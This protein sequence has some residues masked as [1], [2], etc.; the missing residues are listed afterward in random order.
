M[1]IPLPHWVQRL[2]DRRKRF[3]THARRY[4]R[5][6]AASLL[7][8]R[9][10]SAPLVR[11]L[12]G[13]HLLEVFTARASEL[14][15]PR[16]IPS[17]YQIRIATRDDETALGD[18]FGDLDRVH[19]RRQRGDVCLIACCRE[20][21]CAAVWF[22][23]GP[24][25]YVDDWDDLQCR[26]EL[27]AGAV[28]SYDGKGTKLGAWGSLMAKLPE[29]LREWGVDRVFTAIDYHN[30]QSLSGHQSLGYRRLGMVRRVALPGI[31]RTACK[32][33]DDSWTHLPADWDR[34][35]L[36]A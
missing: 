9:L 18:Y 17:N 31:S 26:F 25:S 35:Q 23:P 7:L 24:A 34:L 36:N 22:V 4:G 6:R 27:P 29:Q 32:S 2:Q 1:R 30:G 8:H 15:V 12:F 20:E 14:K 21:I 28:W 33:G 13:W 10:T 11:S 3:V 5:S 19:R 16:C